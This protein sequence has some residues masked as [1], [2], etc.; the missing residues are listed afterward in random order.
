MQRRFTQDF[1][2]E[3]LRE[4]G[5]SATGRQTSGS[6]VRILTTLLLA[7]DFI[8]RLLA[9]DPATRMTLTQALHHPWLLPPGAERDSQSLPASLAAVN[10]PGSSSDRRSSR[11]TTHTAGPF[12]SATEDANED[13]SFPMTNLHIRTPA[14]DR[15]VQTGGADSFPDAANQLAGQSSFWGNQPS[16]SSVQLVEDESQSSVVPESHPIS[17]EQS[18]Y[19]LFS[20]PRSR[21]ATQVQPPR[22]FLLQESPP[23][24]PLTDAAMDDVSSL[25]AFVEG[26]PSS[27]PDFVDESVPN[28]GNKL[29]V[30]SVN[31]IQVRIPNGAKEKV[32]EHT[33]LATPLSSRSTASIL[34]RKR[35]HSAASQESS[36]LSP[37]PESQANRPATISAFIEAQETTSAGTTPKANKKRIATMQGAIPT[38]SSARLRATQQSSSGSNSPRTPKTTPK[39]RKP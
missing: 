30:K 14:L 37:A 25:P 9:K 36:D 12:T 10:L 7:I 19:N 17:Q 31:S 16:L 8:D 35:S 18:R 38:R 13:C 11:S 15:T 28:F 3:L 34:K 33:A 27:L 6:P 1:D 22:S 39:A 23:S 4:I 2:R 29:P 20:Q 26:S 32:A 21:P 5:I 24:P